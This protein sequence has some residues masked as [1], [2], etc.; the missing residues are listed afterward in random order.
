MSEHELVELK[1]DLPLQIV[2]PEA[3]DLIAMAIKQDFDVGRLEK[4]LEMQE[5]HERRQAE[6]EFYKAMAAFKENPPKILK[7]TLATIPTKSGGAMKYR[8][9]RLGAVCAALTESLAQHGLSASWQT[10]QDSGLITVTCT[11]EHRGGHTRSTSLTGPMSENG[12]SVVQKLASTVTFLQRYTLLAIAGIATLDQDDDDGHAAS[13]Q[14]RD[15]SPSTPPPPPADETG[16]VVGEIEEIRA[17]NDKVSKIFVGGIG[18]ATGQAD[19]VARAKEAMDEKA[20]VKIGWV[21]RK[22]FIFADSLEL[23]GDQE[24]ITP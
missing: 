18:Y 17:V 2:R 11:L 10:V 13:R 19:K 4:L 15:P 20:R 6:K 3:N 7:D 22:G 8:Y 5:K 21:K 1:N 14:Y 16:R 9:A 23:V 12:I 24:E